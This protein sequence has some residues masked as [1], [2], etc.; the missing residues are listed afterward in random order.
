MIHAA[1]GPMIHAAPAAIAAKHIKSANPAIHLLRIIAKPLCFRPPRWAK[2]HLNQDSPDEPRTVVDFCAF[3]AF[4]QDRLAARTTAVIPGRAHLNWI[5][6]VTGIRCRGLHGKCA[7]LTTS[8][9][10]S[11]DSAFA[12]KAPA[13]T[14]DASPV[15]MGRAANRDAANEMDGNNGI[16]R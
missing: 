9:R 4:W 5:R 15:A 8:P 6:F 14:S 16:F 2:L 11:G 7:D 13:L 12:C 10:E 1:R 3:A